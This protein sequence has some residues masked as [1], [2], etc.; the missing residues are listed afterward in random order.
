MRD[1]GEREEGRGKGKEGG[2]GNGGRIERQ[3]RVG[4]DQG[5]GLEEGHRVD[6]GEKGTES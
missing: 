5:R 2:E 4:M 6:I 3:E 1:N